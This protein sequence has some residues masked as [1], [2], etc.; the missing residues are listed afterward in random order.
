MLSILVGLGTFKM[1]VRAHETHSRMKSGQRLK[2]VN[3]V[4]TTSA[5][6]RN[7][8]VGVCFTL[9]T[10]TSDHARVG[11]AFVWASA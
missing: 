5:F 4:F 10:G 6:R 2:V 7:P 1:A 9:S 3:F 8:K 11:Q